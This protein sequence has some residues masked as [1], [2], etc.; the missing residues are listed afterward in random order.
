MGFLHCL[1][2]HQWILVI[3]KLIKQ[4]ELFLSPLASSYFEIITKSH[5]GNVSVTVSGSVS[6]V[7]ANLPPRVLYAQFAS[8]AGVSSQ[9]R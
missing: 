6:K 4:S 7:I 5:P 3:L 2:T 1:K 8:A 9:I